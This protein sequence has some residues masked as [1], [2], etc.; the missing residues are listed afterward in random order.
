MTE[1]DVPHNDLAE[2]IVLWHM[3]YRPALIDRYP[4]T[5]DLLWHAGHKALWLS[6]QAVDSREPG[7]FQD[8]LYREVQGHL[9]GLLDFVLDR[10]SAWEYAM[11]RAD[12]ER[13]ATRPLLSYRHGFTWWYQRLQECSH[14]RNLMARYWDRI[15]R[16]Q[17]VDYL[18][19]TAEDG[20]E[21]VEEPARDLLAAILDVD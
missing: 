8:K 6:M 1:V 19:H 17:R 21:V 3:L 4:D 12:F 10:Q 2:S 5:G 15:D 11:H 13:R 7:T 14:A 20:T 9:I 18:R 16:L